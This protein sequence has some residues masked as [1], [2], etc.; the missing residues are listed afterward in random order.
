MVAGKVA[1]AVGAARRAGHARQSGISESTLRQDSGVSTAVRRK[2]L[3]TLSGRV[4]RIRKIHSRSLGWRAS[5]S[6]ANDHGVA[7][8]GLK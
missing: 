2:R 8:T 3:E 4:K 1:A 6:K 7:V 5:V